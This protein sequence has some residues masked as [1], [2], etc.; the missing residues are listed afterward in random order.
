MC[1]CVCARVGGHAQNI[2]FA[3][4]EFTGVCAVHMQTILPCCHAAVGYHLQSQ[5]LTAMDVTDFHFVLLAYTV[6]RRLSKRIGTAEVRL[7]K[8]SG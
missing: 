7:I 6:E 1:V 8:L 2:E 3:T 5:Y 4:S